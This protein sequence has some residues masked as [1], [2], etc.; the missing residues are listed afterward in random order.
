[1]KKAILIFNLFFIL[2]TFSQNQSQRE[3]SIKS[4]INSSLD[5]IKINDIFSIRFVNHSTRYVDGDTNKISIIEEYRTYVFWEVND[6]LFIKKIDTANVYNDVKVKNKSLYNFLLK[7]IE[8]IKRETVKPY[9]EKRDKKLVNIHTSDYNY[10]KFY[11]DVNDTIFKKTFKNF[12]IESSN[13][14]PNYNFKKNQI[15]KT[16]KLYNFCV[17]ITSELEKKNMFTIL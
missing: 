16:I 4:K 14:N 2:L 12:D 9:Q 1:M 8:I 6:E 5:K 10:I 13:D 3:D 11:F 15:L 17:K 7:N